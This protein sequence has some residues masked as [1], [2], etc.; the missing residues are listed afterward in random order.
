[1]EEEH[2]L[3]DPQNDNIRNF[4]GSRKIAVKLQEVITQQTNMSLEVVKLLFLL[5]KRKL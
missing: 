1:M 5:L 2:R 3:E 4:D